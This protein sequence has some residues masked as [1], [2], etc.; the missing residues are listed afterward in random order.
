[1]AGMLVN[2][3]MVIRRPQER[4]KL[5]D[6]VFE[7]KFNNLASI[8]DEKFKSLVEQLVNIK[9]NHLKHL[10]DDIVNNRNEITKL[11]VSVT[12]LSTVLEERL[13]KK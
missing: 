6:A 12:K 10:Q 9:T 11:S 4:A 13:P 1:M 7:T 5:N 3:Y 2:S 8:M